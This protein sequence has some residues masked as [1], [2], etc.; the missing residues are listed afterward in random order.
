MIAESRLDTRARD[1]R[2]APAVIQFLFRGGRRNRKILGERLASLPL[3][4]I[5]S[6]L[7]MIEALVRADGVLGARHRPARA[8]NPIG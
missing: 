6:A 8:R 1:T 5:R 2:R 7:E 3:F 4:E